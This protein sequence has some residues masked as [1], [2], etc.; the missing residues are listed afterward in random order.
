MSQLHSPVS[1]TKIPE[2]ADLWKMPQS[3]TGN[4]F[5]IATTVKERAL[6]LINL[7][8]RQKLLCGEAIAKH[9]ESLPSF[10]GKLSL[11]A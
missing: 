5:G 9:C 10:P 1:V 7:I 6:V 4:S 11:D 2:G 8:R 3:E